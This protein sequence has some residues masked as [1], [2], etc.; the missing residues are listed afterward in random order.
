MKNMN[1][2]KWQYANLQK[3]PRDILKF[4]YIGRVFYVSEH[5]TS[6]H[7]YES[8]RY[9]GEDSF[10]NNF[11]N[12]S[13]YVERNRKM[14]S[15][16]EIMEIPAI[17]VEGSKYAI[18]LISSDLGYPFKAHLNIPL[19]HKFLENIKNDLYAVKTQRTYVFKTELKYIDPYDS[20][21]K[22]YISINAGSKYKLQWRESKVKSK[23]NMDGILHVLKNIFK[24][25]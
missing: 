10:H 22:R 12:A 8:H 5:R 20:I 11:I 4:T 15:Y 2:N 3:F 25:I 13:E 18:C 7:G 17:V 1:K 14:G 6:Y 9:H 16:F 24:L 21:S 19:E 23:I